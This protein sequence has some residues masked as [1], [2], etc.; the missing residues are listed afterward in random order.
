MEL[1]F[2]L[3]ESYN[4][5]IYLI[6]VCSERCVIMKQYNTVF[7]VILLIFSWLEGCYF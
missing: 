6:S 4:V 1:E 7:S 2:C 3:Q 5:S